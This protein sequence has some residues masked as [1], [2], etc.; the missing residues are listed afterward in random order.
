MIFFMDVSLNKANYGSNC[1]ST[2]FNHTS[3]Q[4]EFIPNHSDKSKNKK[5]SIFHQNIQG[6]RFKSVELLCHLI[7]NYQVYA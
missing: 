3:K 2:K 4:K 6:V 1:E 5:V 7:M